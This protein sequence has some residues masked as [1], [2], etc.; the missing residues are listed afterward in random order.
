MRPHWQTPPD[1]HKAQRLAHDGENIAR[2]SPPVI[3]I[4]WIFVSGVE[5]D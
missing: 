1:I 2:V 5:D 3:G 4:E